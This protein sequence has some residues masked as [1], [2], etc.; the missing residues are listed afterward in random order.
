VFCHYRTAVVKKVIEGEIDRAVA[1]CKMIIVIIQGDTVL[2][3]IVH[4][5]CTVVDAAER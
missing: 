2:Y 4:A 1:A 3:V 5:M